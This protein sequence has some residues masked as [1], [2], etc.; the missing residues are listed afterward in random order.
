MNPPPLTYSRALTIAGSDSGGG[1]GIQA[2]LKTFFALG[3][4]GTSVV[5]A[6]TAQNTVGVHGIA[7][8]DAGLVGLQIQSVLGDIGADAVKLGMLHDASI[9]EVV[10]SQLTAFGVRNVVL[11]PVMVAKSGD[12]LLKPAAIHS[13]KRL[14]IPLARVITPNLPEAEALL[15][16]PVASEKEMEHAALALLDLGAEAAL[17]KG[18]HA[19]GP[20]SRDCLAVR[21]GGVLWL[22]APRVLTANTHGTGCTLSSAIT[23]RLALGDSV[24]AAVRAAKLYLS[25]ALVSG[26]RYRLGRGHGPLD[27]RVRE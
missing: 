2:D 15:G 13:L 8:I 12:H 14:L 19:A 21:G 3:V 10:A 20:E 5:T 26:A 23:A 9:I 16:H 27:H 7:P 25:A 22:S 17:V 11:D 18:G 1:A 4:Y 24:V 6:V